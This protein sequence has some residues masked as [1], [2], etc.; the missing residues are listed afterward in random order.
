MKALL[1]PI[2]ITGAIISAIINPPTEKTKILI[3]N[4]RLTYNINEYKKLEGIY[5]IE[6]TK[7]DVWLRGNYTDNKRSGNWYAFNSNKTV[8]LRYNYDLKKLVYLDTLA[9]QKAEIAITDRNPDAV[10]N[11]SIL[12]P[13]CSIDQYTSLLNESAKAMFPK[14]QIVFNKPI[15]I[16]ITA[17]VKSSANINYAINYRLDGTNYTFNINPRDMDYQIEWLPSTYNGKDVEAEFKVSSTIVFEP[18]G[19]EQK[20]FKWNY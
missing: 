8:F 10:K 9:L 16:V 1:L 12:L 13:V 14:S 15:D 5:F 4:S 20:R 3:D 6:N 18:A 2:V 19:S 17:K 7:K 11:G